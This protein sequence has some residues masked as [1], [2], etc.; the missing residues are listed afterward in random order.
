LANLSNQL[1]D[2][3]P[4]FGPA[5]SPIDTGNGFGTRVFWTAAIPDSDLKVDLGAGT[6]ELHV[7]NLAEY[8]YNNFSDSDQTDWNQPQSA[9]H[10]HGFFDANLSFDIVWNGPVTQRDA[11]TDTANGFNGVFSQENATVTWSMSSTRLVAGS[12]FT[13]T[14]NPG[15]I[16]TS[17]NLVGPGQ[18]AG[19]PFVQLASEQN[20]IFFPSAASLQP[21]PMDPSRMDLV[22]NGSST[23]GVQIE[24]HAV[25]KGKDIRVEIEGAGQ[26]YQADFPTAAVSR[27]IVNSGPGNNHIEVADNVTVP[28]ILLGS[29]GNDHIEAGGGPTLVIGGLGRDHL[30][31]GSGGAV[32]IAGTTD[33]DRDVLALDTLLAEWSRTDESYAQKVANLSNG[34]VSGVSPNGQGMNGS[35]FLNANPSNGTVTVHDDG[36]G[37]VLEGG[38]GLDWFFA[39]LDGIDNKGVMDRVKD[40]QPS[41]IVTS[42][43]SITM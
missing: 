16:A 4:G 6:A 8:D 39:N 7:H 14:S 18:P 35:N 24:V 13:F 20:G 38:D 34:T 5:V 9:P 26:D 21:D 1:H 31:A 42:I 15:N 10:P 23:G 41:E 36:A 3:N 17:N 37:N 33:F 30:E 27:L 29:Y 11:V 19:G 40:L 22:V 25:H 12:P 43:T 28:A 2:V 32:L